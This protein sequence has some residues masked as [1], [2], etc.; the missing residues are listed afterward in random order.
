[1]PLASDSAIVVNEESLGTPLGLTA[2]TDVDSAILSIVV[3]G[4]P[5]VGTIRL[6]DGTVVTDGMVLTSAQLVG[7]RYDAP[8][9]LAAVTST[10]FSYAVS[11]GVASPVNGTTTI[12]VNP[13]NDAPVA[14][15]A[16]ITV[17]EE[18]SN[19]SLGLAAPSDPDSPALSIT[20]TGLP[21]LG[22]IRLADGR[23]VTLGMSLSSAQLSSLYYDAPAELASAA[24]L[25]FSYSVSDG[26]A[27]PMTGSATIT[28]N[29]VNDPPVVDGSMITVDE[30]STRTP[31]GLTPPSDADSASLSITVTGL[32]GEGRVTL[33]DGSAVVLGMTLS[34]TQLMGLLYDAPLEI[35]LPTTT[36]FTYTVGDGVGPPVSGM[37]VIVI[38]P[39]D[40]GSVGGGEASP[41]KEDA[42]RTINT[43]TLSGV[44]GMNGRAQD[45]AARAVIGAVTEAVDGI[46]SLNAITLS[47]MQAVSSAAQ[48]ADL[49]PLVGRVRAHITP[50]LAPSDLERRDQASVR[51]ASVIAQ[52]MDRLLDQRASDPTAKDV[53]ERVGRSLGLGR[54]IQVEVFRRGQQD[55][56]EISDIAPDGTGSIVGMKLRM[57]EGGVVPKWIRLAGRGLLL[58]D[59][60]AACEEVRLLLNIQREGGYTRSHLLHIQPDAVSVS[61]PESKVI[62]GATGF[63]EQLDRA[64]S[65]RHRG[66]V[67]SGPGDGLQNSAE[68]WR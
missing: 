1:M 12:T 21:T 68:A 55:L 58:V 41:L 37:A 43:G 19:T 22:S 20:V 32:P 48:A 56:V 62:E 47:T 60:P 35:A 40:D 2:P 50:L 31:L 29:P 16:S 17:N 14:D 59:R 7:L 46:Q 6:D 57:P 27:A 42:S 5:A 66:A 52:D 63:A 10:S 33:A 8:P 23:V 15:N 36:H 67:Q 65:S 38:R 9:D 39:L 4:L 13:V 30:E 64:V 53:V 11:D 26:V 51:V 44:L 28:V 61:N 18:S 24:N 3:T 49:D 54:D 34:A 25:R 45:G